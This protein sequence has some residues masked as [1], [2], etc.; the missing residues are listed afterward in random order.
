MTLSI[1]VMLHFLSI[2]CGLRGPGLLSRYSDSLR[3]GRSGD[4]IRGRGV[5]AEIFRTRPDLPRG[6]PSFLY[7]VFPGDKAAGAPKLKKV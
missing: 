3:D 5:G 6:P 7:R 1:T 2:P 4:R